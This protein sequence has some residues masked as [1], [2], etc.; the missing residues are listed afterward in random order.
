MRLVHAAD[1]HLGFRQ[2]DRT[3]PTGQNQREA[4]VMASFRA[5]VDQVIALA[6]D[7]VVIGGDVFHVARPSNGVIIEACAEFSRL[8]AALPATPIIIAAGNHDLPKQRETACIVQ[9]LVPR[10]IYFAEHESPRLSFPALDLSVLVVPDSAFAQRPALEP[11][12][13][14]RFNVLVMHGEVQGMGLHGDRRAVEIRTDEIKPATWDYVALGHW[15][16]YRT[17]GPNMFYSGSIDY[18]SSNPWGELEDE[19]KAG[20]PG[21]GFIERTLETGAHQFHA[22]PRSRRHV[23]LSL[24]ASDMTT[25][26]LDAS[27]ASLLDANAID[28]AIVR[29]VVTD[30][31]RDVS[32]AVNRRKIREFQRRAL[33]VHVVFRRPE[34]IRVN[35]GTGRA[36]S[37]QPLDATVRDFITDTHQNADSRDEVLALAQRYLD[38]AAAIEAPV[39]PTVENTREEAA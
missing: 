37:Q 15:H 5:F 25:E 34:I 8:A 14:A 38:A 32:R 39:S 23:D 6:P 2:F 10:G 28:D 9:L 29:V 31:T 20:L 36:Q 13:T 35:D 33:N 3:T 26:H 22:L 17:M 19:R 16:V 7:V 11:D 30:V 24:N 27:L 18:T 21:K 4:D 1:L 12:P